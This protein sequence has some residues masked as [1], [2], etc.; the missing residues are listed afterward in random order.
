MHGFARPFKAKGVQRHDL[1]ISKLAQRTCFGNNFT[2]VLAIGETMS[3]LSIS[4]VLV[5][6]GKS[7]TQYLRCFPSVVLCVKGLLGN[8]HSL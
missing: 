7:L 5:I 3:S 4:S 8:V 6:A 2:I 1:S